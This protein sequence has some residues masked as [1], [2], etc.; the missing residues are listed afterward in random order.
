MKKDCAEP[1][2]IVGAS[3]PF[4]IKPEVKDIADAMASSTSATVETA[5]D[6]ASLSGV[7]DDDDSEFMV[8]KKKTS[9]EL[10]RY[11]VRSGCAIMCADSGNPFFIP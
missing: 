1:L 5:T 2:I 7:E 11:K 8:I 9:L 6:V 3:V 10:E 4:R